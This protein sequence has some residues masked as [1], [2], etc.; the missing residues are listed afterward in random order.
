MKLPLFA[1]M[2]GELAASHAGRVALFHKN[3]INIQQQRALIATLAEKICK[4]DSHLPIAWQL[5]TI[6]GMSRTEYAW[7]HTM[8]PVLRATEHR[9]TPIPHGSEAHPS[10]VTRHGTRSAKLISLCPECVQE[11]LTQNP[12]SW[13]RRIHNLEGIELCATHDMPLRQLDKKQNFYRMPHQQL[14]D[15][16]INRQISS[17]IE[18]AER[19]F[20]KRLS[21]SYTLFLERDHP[22]RSV[23]LND[24]LTRRA[25]DLEIYSARRPNHHK[26]HI[27]E[28]IYKRTPIRWTQQYWPQKRIQYPCTTIDKI[29]QSTIEETT[30]K[31]SSLIYALA[32]ATLFDTNEDVKIYIAQSEGKT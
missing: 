18:S 24:A 5:A 29:P 11:D 17:K 23:Q 22:F 1:A 16:N 2:P 27:S 12:Y 28:Y 26:N 6:S 14:N 10:L 15:T 8:L 13:F 21:E 31:I 25:K 3:A 4:G 20:Q 7:K 30:P 19:Y 32:F 9:D